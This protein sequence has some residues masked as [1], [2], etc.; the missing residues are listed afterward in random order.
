MVMDEVI[1]RGASPNGAGK[2]PTILER[3]DQEFIP[4]VL[5]ELG[6]PEGLNKALR[7]LARTKD[8][9]GALKLY[10]PVHRT[11]HVALME[12]VCDTFGEPRL[13]AQKIESAGLVVRR[14]RTDPRRGR[15]MQ[16]W[17]RSGQTL[18]GW[19]SFHNPAEM[20]DDPE[21]ARR[22]PALRAGND[23]INRRLALAIPTQSFDETTSP[24]FIAPPEVC[25]ALKRTVLYGLVPLASTEQSETPASHPPFDRNLLR[26]HVPRFLR[27]GGPR[28]ITATKTTVTYADVTNPVMAAEDPG[29]AEFVDNL[30]QLSIEFE[31]F[32]ASVAAQNLF[33]ELNKLRLRFSSGATKLAG[34][35]LRDAA[36]KLV[37]G[38]GSNA[39]TQ[40]KVTLPLEWPVIS[41]NQAEKLVELAEGAMRA[42]LEQIA[43][44][45]GRFDDAQA[46]YVVRAFARVKR[47]DGCPPLTV[48]SDNSQPFTVAQWFEAS[49]AVPPVRVN[50]P[51]PF[52][53]NFL[54]N[55]KPNVAFGVPKDLFNLMQGIKLKDIMDGKK[56]SGGGID[57]DWICGFNIPIIT[58]CAFIVLNIFLSLFDLFLMWMI[59]IKICIPVPRPR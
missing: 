42:R 15:V 18:Q 1:L 19:M 12:I 32:G 49:N 23:E 34:D 6:A 40:P 31:A 41:E 38:E 22:P 39:S 30:R 4:A 13:D 44:R 16:A 24:L 10:Q 59:K 35:F 50:L 54:N 11:F 2:G 36:R 17:R 37:E 27:R 28:P 26:S 43:P 55:V 14:L 53:G 48:W 45:E 20:N 52:D 29:L 57:L 8:H 21:V 47:D 7:T 51:N 25:S 5:D 33:R 58:L 3:T 9:N 46:L 56:P